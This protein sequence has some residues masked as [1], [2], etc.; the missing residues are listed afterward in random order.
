MSLKSF[1][2][3]I[4]DFFRNLF[5]GLKPKLQ[6]AVQIGVEIVEKIKALDTSNPEFA[7]LITKIIPGHWDDDIKDKLRAALPE[8]AIQLRLVDA[9][10]GL[11]DP[12]E[13]V[14]AAATF[15]QN[16][17]G[18]IQSAAFHDFSI[19]AAQVAADGELN[20]GDAV[21]LLQYYYEHEVKPNQPTDQP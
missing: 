8:I 4:G 15:I 9:T 1:F 16:L 5:N 6:K 18:D 19:L 13:I 11:T 17:D 2:K 20:F 14:H 7:D 21:M 10:L 3:H 12:N